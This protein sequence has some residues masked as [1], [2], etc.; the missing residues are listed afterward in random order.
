MKLAENSVSG[1]CPNCNSN[2]LEYIGSIELNNEGIYF[3]VKCE[4]CGCEY[5][6]YYILEFDG[7]YLPE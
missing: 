5:R 1:E 3:N 7:N 4:K 6:E 2:E